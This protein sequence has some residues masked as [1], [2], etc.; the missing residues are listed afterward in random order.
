MSAHVQPPA[1][2][3]IVDEAAD[4]PTWLPWLGFALLVLAALYAAIGGTKVESNAEVPGHAIPAT[5]EHE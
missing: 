1:L 2:P 5:P 4:T 3:D